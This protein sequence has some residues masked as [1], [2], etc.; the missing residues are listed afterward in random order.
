MVEKLRDDFEV[1]LS[2]EPTS[3]PNVIVEHLEYCAH[4]GGILPNIKKAHYVNEPCIFW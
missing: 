1:V 3:E 4:R 2:S